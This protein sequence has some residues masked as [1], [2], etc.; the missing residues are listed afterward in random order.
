MTDETL[1]A[2]ESAPTETTTT[3]EPAQSVDDFIGKLLDEPETSAKPAEGDAPAQ[4]DASD[5]EDDTGPEDQD[6]G[7]A[8]TDDGDEPDASSTITPPRSMSAKDREAFHKLPPESQKWLTD[9]EQQMTADYTR[10]TQALAE[11]SKGYEALDAVLAPHR[12]RFAHIGKSEAQVVGQLLTLAQHA[13]A[14]FAGF[15]QEQCRLRGIPLTAL[16]Q[17][18]QAADPQLLATQRRL[19]G[20]EQLITQQQRA[21]QEQ[22][23][24]SISSVIDSFVAEKGAD[25]QPAYP[26][27]AELETDM[28]PIVAALRQSKP[29][30]SHRDY[31]AQAY[32]MAMAG[33]E[34]VSAKAEADRKAK[35][36]A[37]RIA[38]AK[39]AAAE[40]KK[41][42]GPQIQSKGSLPPSIAKTRNIDEFIGGLV[43]ERMRA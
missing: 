42:A 15:V 21:Q 22:Q 29:G 14:D 18:S 11:K 2:P 9:R 26:F 3:S 25:G 5:P 13:D 37:E 24:Q 32:K 12:Q 16:S 40:A 19:Q 28:V 4:A 6:T 8:D 10:K 33:N 34:D 17:P 23:L 7:E 1:G 38:K 43:D 35:Q 20:V 30:L 27:Y 41:A 31:L 39:K 36:E